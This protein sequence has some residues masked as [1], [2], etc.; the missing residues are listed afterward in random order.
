MDWDDLRYFH[1]VAKSGSLSAAADTLGVN[2]STVFRRINA[3][4]K[5]LGTRLFERHRSGYL[6]TPAGEDIEAEVGQ[7]EEQIETLQRR[8]EG[9][10]VRLRGPLRVTTRDTLLQ[11]L[12]TPYLARFASSYPLV[13]LE[14]VVSNQPPGLNRDAHVAV[15]PTNSPDETLIGRR[16]ATIAT[17]VYG[18]E[19]YLALNAEV[20]DLSA[21]DWIG[22]SEGLAELP[23]YSWLPRAFP[24][25]R[26]VFRLN[27]LMGM[28]DATKEA[29]G[30]APLPCFIAD[31][32]P[33]LRRVREPV[34]DLEVGLWLLTHQDLRQTARVR[35]F[36][37]FMGREIRTQRDILE[38]RPATAREEDLFPPAATL[39]D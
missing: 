34:H 14:L 36:L 21:H 4:E 17:A 24:G 37:D 33:T 7:I 18:S 11:R 2:H 9:R 28:L 16:L 1:A 20:E 29:M 30:L 26:I 32:E 23:S 8:V 27:T 5:H 31:P 6:L 19:D 3:F 35:A 22:P 12:L 10:D 38:G 15:A 25:A 39:P 13:E